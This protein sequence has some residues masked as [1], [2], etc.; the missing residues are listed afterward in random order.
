MS[1]PLVSA[2]LRRKRG[3]QIVSCVFV[4]RLVRE[5]HSVPE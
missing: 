3:R 1:N 2:K 5:N 4:E